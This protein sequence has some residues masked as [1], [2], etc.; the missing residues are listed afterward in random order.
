MS[1]RHVAS[2]QTTWT[3]RHHLASFDQGYTG[4][5]AFGT[6]MT[7]RCCVVSHSWE[8]RI[9]VASF[10][11]ARS[12]ICPPILGSW[13]NGLKLWQVSK[14]KI[15]DQRWYCLE[16]TLLI[17]GQDQFEQIVQ[18]GF[19][20]LILQAFEVRA[21]YWEAEET[22]PFEF[23]GHSFDTEHFPRWMF[24]WDEKM[25]LVETRGFLCQ[26]GIGRSS[27][28]AEKQAPLDGNLVVACVWRR[29]PAAPRLVICFGEAFTKV[30][31]AGDAW[32]H[33][34]GFPWMM[35]QYFL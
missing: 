28:F 23:R 17:H 26:P 1:N 9:N 24:F 19:A 11:V 7:N 33:D 27:F 22:G 16:A 25:H 15:S 8:L 2:S 18:S 14:T 4:K 12:L 10:Q 20:R 29:R 34:H 35:P 13:K 31:L 3:Q 5:W 32:R 6:C 21:S 30:G